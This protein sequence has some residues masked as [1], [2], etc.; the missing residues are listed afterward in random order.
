MP[1]PGGGF[2]GG[3]RGGGSR[4]GS[5]G[6]FSG[7][8]RGGFSGHHG[9]HHHYY[10]RPFHRHIFFH[11]PYYGYGG[12]GGLFFMPIFMMLIS[13]FLIISVFS[14][15][16]SFGP[17]YSYGDGF[18]YSEE[19]LQSFAM[20]R[21]A[22]EFNDSR[23]YEDN[24]LIVFLVNDSRD[25]YDCIAVVGDNVAD[26]IYKM[27]GNEFTAFGAEIQGNV[28][29][30]YENSLGRNL[31]T[32]INGLT[33]RI[34]N[35]NLDS[36]FIN[37]SSPASGSLPH[38]NNRSSLHVNETIINNSLADF[39]AKTDIPIALVI[40]DVSAVYEADRRFDGGNI[41]PIIVAIG[42]GASAI[43]I[44]VDAFKKR[45]AAQAEGQNPED[46]DSEYDKKDDPKDNST[47][48]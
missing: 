46:K 14:S 36:S 10:H 2:S 47:H 28:A 31:A 7:G 48:W 44:F 21:Y 40:E 23:A 13:V 35:M 12:F 18:S 8:S 32:A 9:H 39:T 17:D 6:G 29:D 43:F 34:V 20:D 30:Y 25:G 33:D 45:K 41:I 4:G 37:E 3:S 26:P 5:R 15:M 1:S 11:R 27:F 42:F 16:F 38:L 24:L 22:V 19:S